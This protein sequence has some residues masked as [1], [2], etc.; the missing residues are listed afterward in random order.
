MNAVS[1]AAAI[2]GPPT[3]RENKRLEKGHANL[4]RGVPRTPVR[5]KHGGADLGRQLA[6]PANSASRKRSIFLIGRSVQIDL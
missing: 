5:A 6:P 2:V 1:P 3:H 4:G